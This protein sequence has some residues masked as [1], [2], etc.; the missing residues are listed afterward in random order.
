MDG[1]LKIRIALT[2]TSEGPYTKKMMSM[3]AK[4]YEQIEV[5]YHIATKL[6]GYLERAGFD[7]VDQQS[8]AIP[9]GEWSPSPS[10]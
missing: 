8:I 1:I 5:D 2:V 7:S 10:K 4:L 3:Y 9:L 6:G